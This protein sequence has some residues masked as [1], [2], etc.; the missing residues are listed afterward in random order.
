M[1]DQ[2][3]IGK[4][5]VVTGGATGIGNACALTLARGGAKIVL[6]DVNAEIGQRRVA[7]I[8]KEGGQ[9]IFTQTDVSQPEAV[10][11][12]VAAALDRFGRLDL[13]VN[14]AGISG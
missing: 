9:A 11:A 3:F 14:N 6:A 2:Q 13:A 7:E 4:V 10:E 5:A 12:M 8:E 1:T